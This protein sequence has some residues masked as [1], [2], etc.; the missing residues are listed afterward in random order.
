MAR[1]AS[2]AYLKIWL[3]S[4]W[5]QTKR[6][7]NVT[8][9]EG[10]NPK[11]IFPISKIF[12]CII[13]KEMSSPV[14]TVNDTAG[15]TCSNNDVKHKTVCLKWT[16]GMM[17]MMMMTMMM[18]VMIM[19]PPPHLHCSD[20]YC[21]SS[22]LFYPLVMGPLAKPFTFYIAICKYDAILKD[23]W[24]G[25]VTETDLL[26]FLP[27]KIWHQNHHQLRP[28]GF[29]FE[30]LQKDIEIQIQR[31][32]QTWIY[33]HMK[34]HFFCLKISATSIKTCCAPPFQFCTIIYQKKIYKYKLLPESRVHRSFTPSSLSAKTLLSDPVKQQL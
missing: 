25:Y 19:N 11:L 4:S 29:H 28:I 5:D 16:V 1:R 2:R 30:Q 15:T 18:I 3:D 21:K 13:F 24:V 23:K 22:N 26:T 10:K 17:T 32:I 12:F 9:T 8:K 33:K 34:I 7:N 20:A 14:E 31:E 27:Q 6:R